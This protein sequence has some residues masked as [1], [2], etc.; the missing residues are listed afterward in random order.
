MIPLQEYATFK[1]P[2]PHSGVETPFTGLTMS[3][4][5]NLFFS[6]PGPEPGALRVHTDVSPVLAQTFTEPFVVFS[7]KRFP[8][9]PGASYL[10]DSAATPLSND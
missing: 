3:A 10:H 8:G 4:S 1:K 5:A 2:L 7:A 9:V 6:P